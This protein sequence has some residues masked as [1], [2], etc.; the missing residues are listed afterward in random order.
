MSQFLQNDEYAMLILKEH[1]CGSLCVQPF[2][3]YTDFLLQFRRKYFLGVRILTNNF[4]TFRTPSDSR[5][6]T[7]FRGTPGTRT[8]RPSCGT[9]SR[10]RSS[11]APRSP[12][13]TP[14]SLRPS[15]GVG[16]GRSPRT[17]AEVPFQT[18]RPGHR[19]RNMTQRASWRRVIGSIL[20][21]TT[22]SSC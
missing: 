17:R 12:R 8:S 1:L 15:R 21:A 20:T 4:S 13:A 2:L 19:R 7:V 10:P 11:A 22:T 16:R 3:K 6:C 9:S 18:G 5:W 14:A